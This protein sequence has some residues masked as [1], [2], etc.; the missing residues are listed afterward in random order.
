MKFVKKILSIF[1]QLI[2]KNLYFGIWL[3]AIAIIAIFVLIITEI[4]ARKLFTSSIY[5]SNEFAGYFLAI[6]IMLSLGDLC[7]R[8]QHLNVEIVVLKLPQNV[9]D[10]TYI[11]FSIF[12]F[13]I[14]SVVLTYLCLHLVIQAYDL[15]TFSPGISRIPMW[16]PQFFMVLGLVILDI[17]LGS[18]IIKWFSS[19]QDQ[20]KKDI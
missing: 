2:N 9:R 14:Y 4:V 20:K 19:K 11:V 5:I 17:A 6:V 18:E 1:E 3:S 10:I 16:I 13:L 12:A 15:N 7:K 8:R